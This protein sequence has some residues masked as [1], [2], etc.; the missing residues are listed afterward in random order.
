MVT[1]GIITGALFFLV[2]V[3]YDRAHTRDMNSF[4]GLAKQMPVYA[5][6]MMM[7]SF[8]SLGLPTLA[9]FVSEFM[10]FVGAFGTYKIITGCRCWAS[11]SP[12]LLPV[13][14]PAGLPGRTQPPVGG[15][16]GHGSRRARAVV[17][18]CVLMLFIGVYPHPVLSFINTA[19]SRTCWMQLTRCDG[20]G[21][22][23]DRPCS[24]RPSLGT[25][26][27]GQRCNGRWA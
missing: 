3:I 10:V 27:P 25:G 9:G 14:D 15:P 26:R 13:D 18:L 8:A 5:G 21:P 11:S 22:S 19:M 2:G 24:R 6:L 23:S 20:A 12:R 1:H 7:A 4:G 17:P 16:A